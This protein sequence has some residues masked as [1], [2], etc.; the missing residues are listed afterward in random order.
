VNALHAVAAGL[1]DAFLADPENEDDHQSWT[2]GE[3]SARAADALGSRRPPRWIP[4]VAAA[5]LDAY[6]RP[7]RDRPRE[8]ARFV[9]G[10]PALVDAVDSAQARGRPL[11]VIRRRPAPTRMGPGPWPV[12]AL[13]DVAALAD[14]LGVDVAHLL[15]LSDPRGYARR[16]P[17]GPLRLH[18]HRWVSRPGRV[19]R[20]LE[21]PHPRLRALQRTVLD[22]I[23]GLVPAHPAAHGFVPGRSVRTHA[24]P[25]AAKQMVITLDLVT[26]FAGIT[27]PRIHGMLR[28]AG[29]PEPV[30]HLLTAVTTV[31]TPVD[32]VARM[33]PGGTPE[34][35]AALRRHLARP[36]LA[37]GAPTSPHLANLVAVA[38]DR[39]LTGYATAVGGTYTRYA[40]DLAISGGAGVGHRAEAIVGAV[41]AIARDEGFTVN[42]AKTRVQGQAGRQRITGLVV[43]RRPTV[44]RREYDLLRALLHNAARTGLEAQNRE[45]LRGF[46]SRLEGRIAWVAS[47]DPVR[48]SRLR[49]ALAAV[50]ADAADR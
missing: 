20:L 47:V 48:G 40:D 2:R 34:G 42:A 23:V 17:D 31:A 10:Q 18:R 50:P 13:D 7:P 26:F 33:P 49:A 16:T 8:L 43:N 29:Y 24:S 32:V 3:L 41:S 15:W 5:V 21:V 11:R 9:A 1:A 44:A 25:H 46:R 35:R 28:R 27:A 6:P 12:P 36:H 22:Q 30:A 4:R 14:L 19:P 37:Q 45:G 38:L 39:R